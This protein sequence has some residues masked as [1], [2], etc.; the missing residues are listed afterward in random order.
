MCYSYRSFRA[1]V[2]QGDRKYHCLYSISFCSPYYPRDKTV[3]EKYE[4]EHVLYIPKVSEEFVKNF[5]IY[6]TKHLK[7]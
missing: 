1:I 6:S 5:C 3:T 4:V 2:L 7:L